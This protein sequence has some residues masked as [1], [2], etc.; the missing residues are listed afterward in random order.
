MHKM[1]NYV[2]ALLAILFLLSCSGSKT[3]WEAL[4]KFQDSKTQL[5]QTGLD[6][7]SRIEACQTVVDT[8]EAFLRE[9]KAGEY[10]D[11]ARNALHLWQQRK[12]T[13]ERQKDY[14]GLKIA[15]EASEQV[16]RTTYDYDVRNQ[17]CDNVI[18][19]LQIFLSKYTDAEE[20]PIVQTSLEAWKSRRSEL[21]K[22]LTSLLVQF[23]RLSKEKATQAAT[24][25]HSW[26]HIES[27]ELENSEKLTEGVNIVARDVYAVR[28]VGNI[29][30]TSIFKLKITVG[31]TIAADTKRVSVE[32]K[33]TV[34]E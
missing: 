5:M 28:M 12:M 31:G 3:E 1:A 19:A 32:E 4:Q 33:P 9:Y 8:L 2:V 26:S 13:I 22:E 11:A 24:R 29:L 14:Q 34:E 7:D 10:A 23:H 21:D 16:L 30:A 6:H 18:H 15:Q 20:T 27:I 25:Q 17:A